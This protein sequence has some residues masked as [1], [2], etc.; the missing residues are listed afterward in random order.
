VSR[1]TLTTAVLAAAGAVGVL[2]ALLLPWWSALVLFGALDRLDG[3]FGLSVTWLDRL[4]EIAAGLGVAA[5]AAAALIAARPAS[6]R[7]VAAV[8]AVALAAGAVF[9][10][11]WVIDPPD[12]GSLGAA[13]ADAGA[14][15]ATVALLV[16][17][18][19]ASARWRSA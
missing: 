3:P 19:A 15:V 5:V 8:A 10:L 18:L 9:L 7:A 1:G 2:A 11:S 4:P 12:P 13:K 17:A 16:A 14:Y 6:A